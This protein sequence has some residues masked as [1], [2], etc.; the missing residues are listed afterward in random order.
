[1]NNFPRLLTLSNQSFITDDVFSDLGV[2]GVLSDKTR[3]ILKYTCSEQEINR[4]QEFFKELLTNTETTQTFEHFIQEA[5]TYQKWKTLQDKEPLNTLYLLYTGRALLQMINYLESLKNISVFSEL[6]TML[7]IW[8]DTYKEFSKDVKNCIETLKENSTQT[9]SFERAKHRS[10]SFTEPILKLSEALSINSETLPTS[11]LPPNLM[12]QY[13][14][15]PQRKKMLLHFQKKYIG[16]FPKG[17]DFLLDDCEFFSEIERVIIQ[18]SNSWTNWCFPQISSNFKF[19]FIDGYNAFDNTPVEKKIEN[20]FDKKSPFTLIRGFNSGGKT[21]FLKLCGT[22]LLF[23]Q[24]GCPVPCKNAEIPLY[25][26]LS[27]IFADSE[28]WDSGRLAA[29]KLALSNKLQSIEKNGILLVNELFSSTSDR[30][31]TTEIIQLIE[32]TKKRNISCIFVTHFDVSHPDTLFAGV[33]DKG[34]PTYKILPT[35]TLQMSSTKRILK[36]Y[37]LY[38]D[39]TNL[40]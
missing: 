1:M 38:K 29:E 2:T 22:I 30:K 20:S 10:I 39:Q 17:I 9:F 37:G 13:L 24:A 26:S 34:E 8:L 12:I 6:W 33:D 5:Y 19:F 40:N 3:R 21:M 35:P 14:E 32:E 16:S 4:R 11:Q 15:N 36:K 27:T 25:T 31:A 7:T 18:A 28:N 23:G